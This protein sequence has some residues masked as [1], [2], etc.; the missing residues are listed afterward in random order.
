MIAGILERNVELPPEQSQDVC[1]AL[2]CRQPRYKHA[3][4]ADERLKM[5]VCGAFKERR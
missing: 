2:G 4:P 3:L 5:G 1:W